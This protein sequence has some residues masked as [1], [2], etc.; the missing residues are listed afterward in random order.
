MWSIV[1]KWMHLLATVAW[2]GGMFASFFIYMPVISKQLDP[3][4]AG[5]LIAGAMK[6]TRVMVYFSISVFVLSG[7]L[8]VSMHSKMY[9]RMFVGDSWHLYFSGKIFLFL[10]LVVLSIYSFE[11]LAPRIARLA[12]EGPSPK[13]HRLQKRQRISA[14]ISFVVGIVILAVT[15]AL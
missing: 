10:L 5:K 8:L 9:E 15:A 6:R 11:I 4:A 7:V 2:I 14:I 13:L 3:P 12:K 1:I